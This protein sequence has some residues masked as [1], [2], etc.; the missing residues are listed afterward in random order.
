MVNKIDLSGEWEIYTN[1]SEPIE[2]IEVISSYEKWSKMEVPGCWEQIERDKKSDGPVWYRKMF[3]V[4]DNWNN[5]PIAIHFEGVNYYSEVYLNGKKVGSH[6]GGWNGFELEISQ[7]IYYSNQNELLVKVYK[8][9]EK[10]PVRECLAGFF[11]DVGVIFGGIWKPVTL[12]LLPIIT[13]ED[14]FVKPQIEEMFIEIEFDMKNHLLKS[15][16]LTIQSCLYD[17][18]GL[19]ENTSTKEITVT[20]T[21]LLTH[22]SMKVDLKKDIQLWNPN[23]PQLYTLETK[24]LLDG[25]EIDFELT[26]FGMKNLH[27]QEDRIFLNGDPIYLRGVL[28]WGWYSDYIAPIPTR[29]EIREELKKVKESGFNL[30]KH[31]LYVPTK[32]YF[33]IADEMGIFI[34]QELPLWLPE[35]SSEMY[36]RVFYQY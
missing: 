15:Q 33:E 31:C 11:P 35:V 19:L 21:S 27:I 22:Q 6:E 17:A 7:A 20:D 10:Y 26:K 14:I 25:K 13:I 36:N 8:Q 28:H 24:V 12:Q 4:P 9:G 3:T 16:T 30:V 23:N 1:F 2:Q 5:N 29:E 18:N 32:D 34:W